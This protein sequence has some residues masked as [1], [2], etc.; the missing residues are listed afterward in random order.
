MCVCV[1]KCLYNQCIH[2]QTNKQLQKGF[3]ALHSAVCYGKMPIVKYLTQNCADLT[4]N[5]HNLEGTTPI[6]DAQ[7]FG[8]TDIAEYLKVQVLMKMVMGIELPFDER[9]RGIIVTYL[10]IH[11]MAKVS[12]RAKELELIEVCGGDNS[13]GAVLAHVKKLIES[14]VSANAANKVCVCACMYVYVYVCGCVCVC[15]YVC[16]SLLSL[17][18]SHLIVNSLVI[19]STIDYICVA[20]CFNFCVF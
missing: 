15:V 13:D 6:S 7:Q 14:G 10:H 11:T 19:G 18:C 4:I 1:Y 16:V 8:Y 20:L 9:I 3:T 2:K 12:A 5:T 17:C